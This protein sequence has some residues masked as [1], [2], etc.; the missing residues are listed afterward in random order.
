MG[1]RCAYYGALLYNQ[2]Y[3]DKSK[4]ERDGR[5][6]VRAELSHKHPHTGVYVASTA[7]LCTV[8]LFRV[9]EQTEHTCSPVIT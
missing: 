7:Y 6:T 1:N 9:T 2:M 3:R 8:W 4:K 5:E